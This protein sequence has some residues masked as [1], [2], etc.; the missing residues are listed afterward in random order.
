MRWLAVAL[1]VLAI[2]AVAW[3]ASEQH[4]ENCIEAA[5]AKLPLGASDLTAQDRRDEANAFREDDNPFSPG[6][7]EAGATVGE[8]RNR[9]RA[10]RRVAIEGCSRLPF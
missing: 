3:F 5:R 1:A 8:V 7:R 10:R 9:P 2:A 6:E 4:Y